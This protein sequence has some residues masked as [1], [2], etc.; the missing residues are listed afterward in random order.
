MLLISTFHKSL[1]S[2]F[3]IL[4]FFS[5]FFCFFFIFVLNLLICV[6]PVRW[7]CTISHHTHTFS[8][9]WNDFKEKQ[10]RL[11]ILFPSFAHSMT[12]ERQQIQDRYEFASINS[13]NGNYS[14]FSFSVRS[15][16]DLNH[17]QFVVHYLC[18]RLHYFV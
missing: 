12:S 17:D 2:E 9:H 7:I 5:F 11:Q 15:L 18:A 14:P 16:Y 13:L 8:R 6:H 10:K 3:I 1:S 4:R